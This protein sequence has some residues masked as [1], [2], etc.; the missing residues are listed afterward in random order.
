[1]WHQRERERER[2]REQDLTFILERRIG[3]PRNDVRLSLGGIVR[4]M[5]LEIGSFTNDISL[6]FAFATAAT[7]EA[8]DAIVSLF[9]VGS[10]SSAAM[11]AKL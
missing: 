5:D 7:A 8:T 6:Y 3:D 9:Q 10:S 1:M 4:H 11:L 2:E